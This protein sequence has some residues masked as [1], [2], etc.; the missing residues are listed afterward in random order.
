MNRHMLNNKIHIKKNIS[1][2]LIAT[3]MPEALN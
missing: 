1:L 2:N 3:D